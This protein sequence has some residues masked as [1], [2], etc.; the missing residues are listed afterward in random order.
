MANFVLKDDNPDVPFKLVLGEVKDAEGNVIAN[1]VVDT[2]AVSSDGAVVEVT[3]DPATLDGNVHFGAPGSAALT[4]EVKD[5]NTGKLLACGGDIFTLTTGD[6]D[7]VSSV[8]AE[9][10]GITPQPEST[11]GPVDPGTGT[12][13]GDTGDGAPATE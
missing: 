7:S 9:F 12:G 3:F 2:T 5:P 8:T 6:P 4:Y 13:T 10:E 11:T 1:P